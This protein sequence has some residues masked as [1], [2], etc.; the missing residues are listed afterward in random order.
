MIPRWR[1]LTSQVLMI[2]LLLGG[3]GRESYA[4]EN[5]LIDRHDG[6]YSLQW[7]SEDGT[8]SFIQHSTD[9]VN[10]QFT[11]HYHVGDASARSHALSD[12]RGPAVNSLSF[13][14]LLLHPTNPSDPDDTDGDGLKNSFE[15]GNGYSP[16]T[17]DSDGNGT[18]DGDEDPDRDGLTNSQEAALDTDPNNGDSDGDGTQDGNEDSDDDGLTNQEEIAIGTDLEVPD[19]DDDGIID[20]QD[21]WPICKALAPERLPQPKYAVICIKEID[22]SDILKQFD[23]NNNARAILRVGNISHYYKAD[24]TAD[25]LIEL[26]SS[27]LNSWGWTD[28]YTYKSL[29][30]DNYFVQDARAIYRDGEIFSILEKPTPADLGLAAI[31]PSDF[32]GY[33]ASV[34]FNDGAVVGSADVSLGYVGGSG[35]HLDAEANLLWDVKGDFTILNEALHSEQDEF[36][37]GTFNGNNIY[38]FVTTYSNSP[39]FSINDPYWGD[40]PYVFPTT[41]VNAGSLMEIKN[42]NSQEVAVGY[43]YTISDDYWIAPADFSWLDYYWDGEITKDIGIWLKKENKFQVLHSPQCYNDYNTYSYP[44]YEPSIVHLSNKNTVMAAIEEQKEVTNPNGTKETITEHNTYIWLDQNAGLQNDEEVNST[45]KFMTEGEGEEQQIV[46]LI[47]NQDMGPTPPTNLNAQMQGFEVDG[48]KIWHNSLWLDLAEIIPETEWTDIKIKDINDHGMLAA[49][50]TNKEGKICAVFLLPVDIVPD[51]NRDGMIDGQDRGKV[52]EDDPWRFWVNDDDDQGVI[53]SKGSHNDIPGEG[54]A[55]CTDLKVDGLRD[56]IDFFPLYLDIRNMLWAAPSENYTYKLSHED[57]A[58]NFGE[59]PDVVLDGDPYVDGVGAYIRKL[60]AAKEVAN[61]PL[62]KAS[63]DGSVISE[64]MLD[65]FKQGRGVLIL[66]ATKETEKPLWLKIFKGS[67]LLGEVSFPVKTSGVEK[68]FRAKNLVS[69]AGAQV[70]EANRMGEP[71]NY[72]DELTNDKAFFMVHGYEPELDSAGNQ[73]DARGFNAEIFKR[74]HQSGSRAKFVGVTW[75][76]ATGKDY[77]QAVINAFK[78]SGSMK[79]VA[80]EMDGDDIVVA[81]HSLGNVVTSNAISHEGFSPTHYF[82]VNAAVPIEAY[83]LGQTNGTGKQAEEMAKW[84]THDKWKPYYNLGLQK[85]F[86]AEWHKLFLAGDNRRKLT[87]KGRFSEVVPVAYNFYSSG[88]DVLENPNDQETVWKNLSAIIRRWLNGSGTGRHAWVSQEMAKGSDLASLVFLKRNHAGWKIN[89]SNFDMKYIGYPD[90]GVYDSFLAEQAKLELDKLGGGRL[91]DEN[92][93]QVGFFWRF[94]LYDQA[95][96]GQEEN[97]WGGLYGPIVDGNSAQGNGLT[98]PNAV[99]VKQSSDEAGRP[100]VQAE[101][102]ASAIPAMSYA[103]GANEL[104]IFNPIIQAS[105]NY[106]MELMFKLNG[107]PIPEDLGRDAEK[108]ENASDW[109]HS[110][111]WVVAPV[112]VQSVYLKW[113]ELAKLDKK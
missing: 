16:T 6:G 50:A 51:Y 106:D 9:L 3:A 69:A 4:Q 47:W 104:D 113:V 44:T 15:L 100:E 41:A 59:L 28:Y 77:H 37:A 76:G 74:L 29:N 17:T 25:P 101:L 83:D 55:D 13:Y 99:T 65:A 93:A 20:G 66:E 112:Y 54:I 75:N 7:D 98:Q 57:E 63:A 11:P 34:V 56:V 40:D 12:D 22:S 5:L 31:A 72:P 23:I 102:L 14:R 2:A 39:S 111:F 68:M 78:T 8:T 53:R 70:T 58:F 42:G 107:W 33:E 60:S 27:Y 84:M 86:T 96:E 45:P 109:F 88:E 90:S 52:N 108:P 97:I 49:Q 48:S 62:K 43:Q 18:N 38:G 103:A 26:P 46:P 67:E 80:A 91:S 92:L 10:W 64:A 73:K 81:A 30:E 79:G 21:G 1:I 94:R 24:A 110:D 95:G 85:L 71:M 36:V 61:L 87:W 105:R 19:T 32:R 89:F 82:M 35:T